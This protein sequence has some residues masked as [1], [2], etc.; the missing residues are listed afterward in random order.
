[1]TSLLKSRENSFRFILDSNDPIRSQFCIYHDS[2][3]SMCKIAICLDHYFSRK[4]DPYF[5]T[6]WAHKSFVNIYGD[7]T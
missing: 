4:G 3:R 6:S 7:D 2:Y 5:T 1:M